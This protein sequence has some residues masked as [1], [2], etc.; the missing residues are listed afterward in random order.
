MPMRRKL[1]FRKPGGSGLK[2]DF[3]RDSGAG[4]GFPLKDCDLG[5]RNRRR[6]PLPIALELVE[7]DRHQLGVELLATQ[8]NELLAYPFVSLGRLVWAA[9]DHRLVRVGDGD[10]ART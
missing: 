4:D 1:R 9:V 2:S 8:A 10:D 5:Q 7:E 6:H 3:A